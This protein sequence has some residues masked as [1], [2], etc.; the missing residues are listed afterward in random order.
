M[1][2]A[3]SA[4]QDAAAK[5][6]EEE[7]HAKAQRYGRLETGKIDSSRFLDTDRFTT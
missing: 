3:M 2:N 1:T 5:I 6:A 7:S 4:R